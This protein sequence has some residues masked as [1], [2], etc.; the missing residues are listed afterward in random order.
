MNI[1]YR[2]HLKPCNGITLK[3]L[4][5]D[6]KIKHVVSDPDERVL[7]LNDSDWGAPAIAAVPIENVLYWERVEESEEN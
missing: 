4:D 6:K 7:Y 1:F 2:I 3:A 5:F